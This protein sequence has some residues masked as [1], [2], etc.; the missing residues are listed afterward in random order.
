MTDM[1]MT[2]RLTSSLISVLSPWMYAEAR[3]VPTE[4]SRILSEVRKRWTRRNF[5]EE[6]NRYFAVKA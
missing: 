5:G 6:M 1:N 2:P 4:K 3:P